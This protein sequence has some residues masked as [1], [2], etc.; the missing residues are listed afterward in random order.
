M[1]SRLRQA[2]LVRPNVNFTMCVAAAAVRYECDDETTTCERGA[3]SSAWGD[4]GD[5]KANGV[6]GKAAAPVQS[7]RPLG[8]ADWVD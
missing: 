1:S 7:V 6:C 5:D 3:A 4:A 8:I 2:P